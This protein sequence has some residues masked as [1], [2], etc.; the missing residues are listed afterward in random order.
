MYNETIAVYDRTQMAWVSV[1]VIPPVKKTEAP[2]LPEVLINDI[3]N[4]PKEVVNIFFSFLNPSCR[5]ICKKFEVTYPLSQYNKMAIACAEKI[6]SEI[7]F[8]V[9][10]FSK[11]YEG[12]SPINNQLEQ[13]CRKL[14]AELRIYCRES[15]HYI[16]MNPI[17]FKMGP[18]LKIYPS[19][20]FDNA[21]WGSVNVTITPL[22]DFIRNANSSYL[23]SW[24]TKHTV[25]YIFRIDITLENGSEMLSKVFVDKL[26]EK[27]NKIKDDHINLINSKFGLTGNNMIK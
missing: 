12:F 25:V 18:I 26:Q 2:I 19:I 11:C 3:F 14:D 16:E 8:R 6:L 20:K 22:F 1:K 9:S 24:Q 5:A 23:W 10:N 21:S 13:D 4:L 27:V 7:T 17:Y 15:D